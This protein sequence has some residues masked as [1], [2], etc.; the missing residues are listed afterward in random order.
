MSLAT[1]S[2]MTRN[3]GFATVTTGTNSIVMGPGGT[4]S[5]GVVSAQQSS[6][7]F[8]IRDAASLGVDFAPVP[9]VG[10]AKS[11]VEFATGYD[12]IAG[13]D[14]SRV[15]AAFGLVAGVA[16]Y[17][18]GL[19]KGAIEAFGAVGRSADGVLGVARVVSR[20]DNAAAVGLNISRQVGRE[21]ATEVGEQGGLNLYRLGSAEAK[22]ESGWREGDRFLHLPNQGTPKANWAQ[23]A[24]SLRREIQQ[25]QPIFDSYRDPVNGLQIPAGIRPGDPGRFLNAERQ[26]LESR[27]WR[28]NSATGAYHPQGK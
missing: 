23:N 21:G 8:G 15:L 16:P 12:Y 14:T 6:S 13:R 7:S 10:S 22:A 5:V 9:L 25:G 11:M 24:G 4:T 17:G 27:G 18:K 28:Y 19:L 26:L 3:M 1:P 20:V 2:G